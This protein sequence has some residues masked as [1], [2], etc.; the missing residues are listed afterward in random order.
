V[1]LAFAAII[2]GACE[3]GAPSVTPPIAPG[4]SGSPREVNLIAKDYSFLPDALDLRL[5]RPSCST[6]STVDL[7]S[8][9]RSSAMPPRRTRGNW[10]KPRPSA[11]H[12]AHAGR[13]RPADAS[14]ASGS[15]WKSGQRV[16]LVWTVPAVSPTVP[17]LVG[18]HIPG[19]WERGMQIP[20]ALGG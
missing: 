7:R 3:A 1:L 18:C 16:D 11:H 13:Q 8:M 4:A 17:W 6:S 5:A 20:G 10:R 2:T 12:P 9:K 19:H 15:S 14:P